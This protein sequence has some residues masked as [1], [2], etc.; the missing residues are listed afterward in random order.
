MKTEVEVQMVAT[1]DSIPAA[2]MVEWTIMKA[3][4]C[5]YLIDSK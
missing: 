3:I 2:M 5:D 1:V 4:H